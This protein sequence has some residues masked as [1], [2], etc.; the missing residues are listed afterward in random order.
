M[1]IFSRTDG[2]VSCADGGGADIAGSWA[3]WELVHFE[4]VYPLLSLQRGGGE[5]E[6]GVSGN[7]CSVELS[8][9]IMGSLL[10]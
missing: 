8:S 4:A 1:G 5:L 2:G 6:G 10:G 9:T 7:F 3:R